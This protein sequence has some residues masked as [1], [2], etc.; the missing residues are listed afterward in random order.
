MSEIIWTEAQIMAA[1]AIFLIRNK[2]VPKCDECGYSAD[3]QKCAHDLGGHCRRSEQ[4]DVQNY[5]S[6]IS[7][8]ERAANFP[9][10]FDKRWDLYMPLHLYITFSDAEKAALRDLNDSGGR[11]TVRQPNNLHWSLSAKRAVGISAQDK[12][13]IVLSDRGKAYVEYL[14]SKEPEVANGETSSGN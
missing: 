5:E 6:V 11:T 9:K 7:S 3:R 10:D 12:Y 2:L 1:R 8:L 14:N 4:E 13:I